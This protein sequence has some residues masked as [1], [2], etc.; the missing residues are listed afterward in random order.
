MDDISFF[1]RVLENVSVGGRNTIDLIK[2]IGRDK[3]FMHTGFSQRNVTIFLQNGENIK[4][5]VHRFDWSYRIL[6]L[7]K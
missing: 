7:Q 1:S 5:N 3:N 6:I 2:R 4:L